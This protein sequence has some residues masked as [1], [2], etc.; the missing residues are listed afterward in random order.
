LLS[1]VLSGLFSLG[2]CGLTMLR[3]SECCKEILLLEDLSLCR[4]YTILHEVALWHI[5]EVAPFYQGQ[6]NLTHHSFHILHRIY[7]Y[8]SDRLCRIML[9]DLFDSV[10]SAKFFIYQEYS[11]DISLVQ[12]GEA[13]VAHGHEVLCDWQRFVFVIIYKNG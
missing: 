8:F 13:T 9:K 10:C 4:L 12:F 2:Y 3:R 1:L 5:P 11:L 7:L 6:H